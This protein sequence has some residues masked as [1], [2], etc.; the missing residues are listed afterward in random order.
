MFGWIK[1]HWK[2]IATVAVGTVVFVGVTALTGGLGAPAMAALFAGGFASGVAGSVTAHLLDHKAVSFGDAVLQGTVAAVLTVATAGLG[3]L[4]APAVS[5]AFAGMGSAA[6]DVVPILERFFPQAPKLV[7]LTSEAGEAGITESGT[8]NGAKGIFAVPEKIAE[9]STLTKVLGTGLSPAKTVR[10]IPLPEAAN[11]HFEEVL[12]L[13]PYSFMKS[14]AGVRIAP[15]GALG[16][17]SG[18]LAQTGS[19]LAPRALIYVPDMLIYATGAITAHILNGDGPSSPPQPS[20][21][22]GM[23]KALD[24]ASK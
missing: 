4:V 15:P 14:L 9:K 22:K 8:V 24:A 6:G 11:A 23:A 2:T 12:P 18:A 17:E 13:G 10:T 7:H 1:D 20:A 21:T 3:R 16:V 5:R 19:M